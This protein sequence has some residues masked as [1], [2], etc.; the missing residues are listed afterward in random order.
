VKVSLTTMPGDPA[1]PGNFTITLEK[2]TLKGHWESVAL[3]SG[4]KAVLDLHLPPDVP[5]TDLEARP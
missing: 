1:L 2:G 5:I 4:D 3:F